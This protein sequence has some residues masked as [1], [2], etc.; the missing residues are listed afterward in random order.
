MKL[1][2]TKSLRSEWKRLRNSKHIDI[3][4]DQRA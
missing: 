4:D 2:R 3:D 1:T